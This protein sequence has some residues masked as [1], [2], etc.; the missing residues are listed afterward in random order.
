MINS[1]TLQNFQ[2]PFEAASGQ[3]NRKPIC[4][5]DV[6]PHN[7]TRQPISD[8]CLYGV[9]IC[10][11]RHGNNTILAS[12]S[13]MQI[14][15]EKGMLY[16]ASLL[17]PA[18]HMGTWTAQVCFTHETLQ[19]LYFPFY[20]VSSSFE[21]IDDCGK[22]S[23]FDCSYTATTNWMAGIKNVARFRILK[24]K[25]GKNIIVPFLERAWMLLKG[26][27]TFTGSRKSA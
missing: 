6:D 11:T 2:Q 19:V 13:R 25:A 9:F 27:I 3:R 8:S 21:V 10:K 24:I 23:L 15:P 26:K 14:H 5:P 7:D 22:Q 1:R 4:Q 20:P 18:V 16:F 12:N 17:F